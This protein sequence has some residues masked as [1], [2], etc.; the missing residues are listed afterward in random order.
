M[1]GNCH[2]FTINYAISYKMTKINMTV[3]RLIGFQL[4]ITLKKKMT[5]LIFDTINAFNLLTINY[6]QK[7]KKSIN[8]YVDKSCF[9]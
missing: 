2:M 6:K 8:N 5:P 9:Y 4:K 7:M 3:Y 1:M